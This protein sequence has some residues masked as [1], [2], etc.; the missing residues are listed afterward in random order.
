MDFD[1]LRAK[2]SN[3]LDRFSYTALPSERPRSRTVSPLLSLISATLVLPDS[4]WHRSRL[5]RLSIYTAFVLTLLCFL[6]LYSG[7][8]GLLPLPPSPRPHRSR[9]SKEE[10]IRAVLRNPV[11]GLLDPEPIS[12]KCSETRFQEGLVWHC[13]T[14]VGGIG[15]V[16]NMWLNCV[17]YAIEAGATTLVLPTLGA[18]ADDLVDLG[19]KDN[20]VDLSLL[21]DVDYFLAAWQQVCPQMRAVVADTDI[22][23]LPAPASDRSPHLQPARVK[24]FPMRKYLLVDPTGWRA[25]F[26]GWLASVLSHSQPSMSAED[27]VRVWQDMVLA[28][29]N[30][31]ASGSHTPAFGNAFPRLFRFPETTKR[32]AA[33]VL[34][35]MEQKLG[36]PV[37]SDSILFLPSPGRTNHLAAGRLAAGAFMGV[38]MRVAADAATAGWPGYEAQAPFFLAEAQRRNLSTI[39]LA[40]GSQ[41]HRDRFRQDAAAAGL[42][43]L[44]K[45]DLLDDG[46]D[47]ERAALQALTWDQ[48][49]LVDF[50]VLVHSSWFYGFVRSSFSWA[51]ALRRGT[52][53]EAGPSQVT[54]ALG[55]EY[56]DSL[57]AVVGRHPNINPEGMWP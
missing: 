41:E 34:W 29:W 45:E 27:P 23:N 24:A 39:Y 35:C 11:E 46:D 26:D 37:V 14:V 48:R 44:T 51:I 1:A 55:D 36:R 12:Q 43:V 3:R 30:R 13:D 28:Q 50:D 16:G 53:P 31:E 52:L 18:R 8:H 10:Y 42:Q 15:N 4:L 33:S 7:S 19:N 38:H 57:S 9:L 49:A 17:R 6:S 5:A 40:T 32:L 2:L 56:R 22:P 20:A 25:A 54:D 21:F 47:E